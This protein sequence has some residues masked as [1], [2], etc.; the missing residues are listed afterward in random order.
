MRVLFRDEHLVAVHKPAGLLVHRSAI[1]RHAT[2]FAVQRV[3]DQLG[4]RVFPVHR[5]D[6]PVSG[7][8]V[9]ALDARSARALSAQFASGEASK[10]YLAVVRGHTPDAASIDYPLR[11]QLDRISD[12]LADPDKPAQPALTH[13][14][15]LARYEL[16]EAV[17]RYASARYSLLEVTPRTGR[18]HQIRRHLKHVFHPIV[19]DTTHG[20]G[21]HNRFIRARFSCARLLLAATRLRVAHPFSGQPL[22][23]EAA[24]DAEFAALVDALRAYPT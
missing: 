23:L 8:L 2:E 6:R 3:R 7:V 24:P 9:F 18:K 1:D 12:A 16:P 14:R 5:L 17:G 13:Y 20:D 4:Q 19:G 11:E 22:L 10:T 15:T 21:K